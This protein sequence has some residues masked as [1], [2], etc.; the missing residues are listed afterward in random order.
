MDDEDGITMENDDYGISTGGSILSHGST[1]H[2]EEGS[3]LH[4]PRM[5]LPTSSSEKTRGMF[6]ERARRRLREEI[7]VLWGMSYMDTPT[8]CTGE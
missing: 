2:H 1:T 5:S 8:V 4:V 3:L 7:N 6:L